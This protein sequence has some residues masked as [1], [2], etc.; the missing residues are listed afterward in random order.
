MIIAAA[1]ADLSIY[2]YAPKK[3]KMSVCGNGGAFK[4]QVKYMVMKILNLKEIP[5][6]NGY[7]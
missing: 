3:V 4:Q 6:T 2:E 5:G 1:Q 7:F